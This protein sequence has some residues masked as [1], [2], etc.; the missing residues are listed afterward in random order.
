[1]MP[2][3]LGWEP[4]A[5]PCGGER[6]SGV[7]AILAADR[8][9]HQELFIRLFLERERMRHRAEVAEALIVSLREQL[10]LSE[11]AVDRLLARPLSL[12]YR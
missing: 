3:S 5:T 4:S 6:L 11:R 8:D 10:R 12:R 2:D 9:A 1:M 7:S